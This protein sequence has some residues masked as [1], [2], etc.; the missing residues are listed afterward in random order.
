VGVSLRY[1]DDENDYTEEGRLSFSDDK[2]RQTWTVDLRNRELRDYEYKYSIIYKGGVVKE[3]PEDGGWYQGEPGFI[4]VGEKY[5]LQ[6]DVFPTLMTYPDH[7]KLVKIDFTYDDPET[8]THQV[9]S[10]VFSK[11]ANAPRPWR[12][13]GTQRGAKRYKYQVTYFGAAP[14]VVSVMP[15]V[16]SESEAL[17][18]PP[19][20]APAAPIG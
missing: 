12:V 10:F 18:V 13:R 8:G 15:P 11:E 16:V 4:T 17:I 3:Y 5:T 2:Q 1:R 6:V 9:D 20:P 14:G 19:A 7:A